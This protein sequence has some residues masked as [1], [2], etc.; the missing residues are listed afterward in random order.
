[1]PSR[2]HVLFAIAVLSLALLLGVAALLLGGDRLPRVTG[3]A[4]IGGS[5]SLTDT[6][7]RRVTEDRK[8]VV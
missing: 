2:R 4:L 5:F 1:M 3:E 7:G 8:S 6:N